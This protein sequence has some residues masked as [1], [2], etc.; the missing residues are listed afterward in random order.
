M[1]S[2]YLQKRPK[3][4]GHYDPTHYHS[5]LANFIDCKFSWGNM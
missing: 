3:K 4:G 1:D 2:R 5:Q